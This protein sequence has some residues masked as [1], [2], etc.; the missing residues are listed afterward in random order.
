MTTSSSSSVTPPA[1]RSVAGALDLVVGKVIVRPEHAVGPGGAELEAVELPGRAG[2]G[3]VGGVHRH[4]LRAGLALHPVGEA[5][6][7]VARDDVGDRIVPRIGQLQQRGA[8]V[9]ALEG[10]AVVIVPVGQPALLGALAAVAGGAQ[11]HDGGLDALVQRVAVAHAQAGQAVGRVVAVAVLP[12]LQQQ[13]ELLDARPALGDAPGLGLSA[14]G[15]GH[16][17]QQQADERDD[18]HDLEQREAGGPARGAHGAWITRTKCTLASTGWPGA[19]SAHTD[20]SKGL[21]KLRRDLHSTSGPTR[22]P[23][24][25]KAKRPVTSSRRSMPSTGWLPGVTSTPVASSASTCVSKLT[26]AERRT[27]PSRSTR[28]SRRALGSL[29]CAPLTWL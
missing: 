2:L 10:L 23:S 19:A 21:R 3:V 28:I 22:R 16:Q 27:W 20:M 11:G 14:H 13:R 8:A 25:L 4:V 1:P 26:R 15:H 5:V 18:H 9:Y 6:A 29:P 24:T 7:V 17:P 12:R